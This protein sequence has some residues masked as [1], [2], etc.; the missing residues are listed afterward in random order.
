M[1]TILILLLVGCNLLCACGSLHSV[2]TIKPADQFILGNNEHG[3]FKVVLQNTS[4]IQI[5]VFMKPIS[6]GSHSTQNVD[7]GKEITIKVDPNTALVI[8]NTSADTVDINL[9]VTGDTGLSMGF[10]NK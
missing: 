2:T 4:N 3:R 8:A 5:Q 7:S 9:K 1:N 6:G 10:Q